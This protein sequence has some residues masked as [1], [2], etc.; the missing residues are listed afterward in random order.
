GKTVRATGTAFD[1][2]VDPERM[3]VTLVDGRVRIES[4]ADDRGKQQKADMRA[5]WR[6]TV[7]EDPHWAMTPVDLRRATSWHDG[8]M[9][10]YHE[11][12]KEALAETNRYSEKKIVFRGPAPDVPVI[13][14][15][16][17]GDV[18]AFAAAVE[19]NKLARVTGRTE[20]VIELSAK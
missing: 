12:L 4:P 13:G 16:R 11:P 19:L 10:F 2:R 18:D 7:T 6:I 9:S 15:F 14:A 20:D 5:G 1:V 3:E 17:S 8:R